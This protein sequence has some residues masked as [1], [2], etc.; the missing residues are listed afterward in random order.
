MSA[1]QS[2][3]KIAYIFNS[4]TIL[5]RKALLVSGRYETP[6]FRHGIHMKYFL[7]VTIQFRFYLALFV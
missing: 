1:V 5:I 2:Y 3:T 7:R 4:I 6:A